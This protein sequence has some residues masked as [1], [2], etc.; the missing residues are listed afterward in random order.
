MIGGDSWLMTSNRKCGILKVLKART[1]ASE[2]DTRGG[3]GG[4][5]PSAALWQCL[6]HEIRPKPKLPK[7]F[8]VFGD[9]GFRQQ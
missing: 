2:W 9:E 6:W 5:T 8:S 4:G 7:S 1:T 3:H